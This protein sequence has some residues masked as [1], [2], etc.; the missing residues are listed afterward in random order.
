MS[1]APV[2]PNHRLGRRN[3]PQRTVQRQRKRGAV[4]TGKRGKR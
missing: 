3:N 4:K 2:N 1:N